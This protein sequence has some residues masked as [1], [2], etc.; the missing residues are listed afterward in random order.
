MTRVVVVLFF[1]VAATR[2][3][4]AQPSDAGVPD[5]PPADAAPADAAPADAPP[6]P[7]PLPVPTPATPSPA[8]DGTLDGHVVDAVTHDA[9]AAATVT[10]GSEL[11]AQTDDHGRFTLT[12]VCPGE[13]VF[14]VERADYNP[15]TQAI[16]AA[17][18]AIEIEMT[19]LASETIEIR[20]KA[21]APTEMRSTA[22]ISGA[23]LERTRGKGF[24]TALADVPGVSELRSATGVAKPIIRGQFG[25]RLLILVDGIRHR[26]QEWGLDHAPE[27]DPFI[28]DKIQVVRG[29][30]GVRYG[31]DAIGGVVLVE[32]PPLRWQ[33]GYSG[34]AHLI[35]S[36]NGRG[37]TFAGRLQA[38]SDRAPGLSTQIEGSVKRLAAA[39]TPTYALD[40]TGLFD[41]GVSATVGYRRNNAEY[42]ISY[43]R[44]QARLGVCACLRIHNIDDFLAQ[45]ELGEP[46]GADAFTSDF[47]IDRPYQTV[48][49]DTALVRGQWDRDHLGT[50]TA[51]YSFQHDLRREYDVVRNA[52]TAGAQFNFRLMSHELEAVFEHNPIHLSEH[53]HLRG[54]AGVVGGA[55]IHHYSGLQLV[56]DFTSIG[57]GVYVTERLIGHS[58]DV[59]LG[60]RYDLLARDASLERI[61][62]L[63]LVRSG[64]LAAGACTDPGADQVTCASRFHTFAGSLGAKQQIG[65]AWSIKGELSV[66]SRAPNTDEQYINGAAPT[67]PVLGLGKP[68]LDPETTYSSSATVAYDGQRLKLEASAYANAID[69]YIYFGPAIGAD[70]MPIF[71][72]LIRGTF[73]RF[74]TKAVDAL[75][76][77][78]DGGI[79]VA[80]IPALELGAQASLVRAKNADDG[81]YLAFVPSDHYRGSI[82]YHPPDL[83]PVRKS[84]VTVSGTYATRQKRFDLAADFIAPPPAY[85]LLGAE[86][87]TETTIADQT[88]RFALQGANLT[89]ARYRD[90]TSLM[91]YFADEPGWQLWLRMSVFFDSTSHPKG[92]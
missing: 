7:P 1:L 36:S 89:N 71:D 55:Q 92:T 46:L 23:R 22:E 82:T 12:R 38:A 43:R 83:G 21:P 29:A 13:L 5:A 57:G 68:D 70:G 37:G 74:S 76:Y 86:L 73:P 78:A 91:R 25:R 9:I 56:P 31:S 54:A 87:G 19:S 40:N 35:G 69:D 66:A 59:E 52:A 60:L 49:H 11:L 63:R 88:V 67:F 14:V 2:S 77:G 80:P 4:R 6:P 20:E 30:G 75:F 79:E 34:E 65:G 64:Q 85:F 24:S 17:H 47:E 62:F 61:D 81:S 45:A 44:Y 39:E 33:P 16:Q 18:G 28:A 51:T 10:V 53:W 58:T 27:I 50:V 84:F 32:P 48:A 72:V 42:K 15:A 41:V 26:S 90:Y 8:C 3:A